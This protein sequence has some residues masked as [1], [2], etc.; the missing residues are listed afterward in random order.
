MS[1]ETLTAQPP[2]KRDPGL[3]GLHKWIEYQVVRDRELQ[4][5]R[6]RGC[7]TIRVLDCSKGLSD[8]LTQGV[9]NSE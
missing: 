8:A 2:Q 9:G 6:D 7:R 3:F 4:E 1:T 5:L